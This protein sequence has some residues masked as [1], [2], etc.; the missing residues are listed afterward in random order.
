MFFWYGNRGSYVFGPFLCEKISHS[1]VYKPNFMKIDKG[2]HFLKAITL[3]PTPRIA[4]GIDHTT[5]KWYQKWWEKLDAEIRCKYFALHQNEFLLIGE[6]GIH[7][8]SLVYCFI[9][10]FSH[11]VK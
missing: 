1:H 2:H 11:K 10:N 5:V 3:F 7:F 6:L 9:V 8:G 4:R